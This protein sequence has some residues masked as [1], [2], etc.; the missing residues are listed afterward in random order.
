MTITETNGA[1]GDSAAPGRATSVAMTQSRN[2]GSAALMACVPTADS[3]L[4]RPIAS[5]TMA[6]R[7]S[8]TGSCW[9][10]WNPV[11]SAQAVS[12]DGPNVR[13]AGRAG[14]LKDISFEANTGSGSVGRPAAPR[15]RFE[16]LPAC[17]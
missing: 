10:T 2:A 12:S 17:R 3:Q 8:R 15:I 7:R 14:Q 4:A 6:A 16:R 13:Q 1:S 9:M 5:L 11:R